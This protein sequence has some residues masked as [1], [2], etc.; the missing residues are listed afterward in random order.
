M[1]LRELDPFSNPTRFRILQYLAVESLTLENWA[2]G[3]GLGR[4]VIR[5]LQLLRLADL[6]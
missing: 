4:T 5:H 1:L 3:P 6:V 2:G